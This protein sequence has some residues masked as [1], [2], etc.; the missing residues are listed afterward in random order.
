MQLP[1][2]STLSLKG[3]PLSKKFEILLNVKF[4]ENVQD[5]LSHCFESNSPLRLNNGGKNKS[6]TPSWLL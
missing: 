3:N 6:E 5:V 4:A 1:K 2:L